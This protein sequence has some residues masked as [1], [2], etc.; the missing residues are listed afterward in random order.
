MHIL[1]LFAVAGLC[2]AY[3]FKPENDAGF[4]NSYVPALVDFTET[5]YDVAS[6][7][8]YWASSFITGDNERQYL[9]ILHILTTRNPSPVCRS[10]VLDLKSLDYWVDLTYCSP[11]NSSAS[12]RSGPLNVDF[13]DYGFGATSDDSVS[14]MYAYADTNNSFSLDVKWE[15]SS[16]AMQNG[17]GGIIAFGPGPSNATEW[18][19]PASRTSGSITLDGS[20]IKI[21]P[22]NSFTWYDRQISYGVPKNWTWFQV[23]FPGSTIKASI[24]AYDLGS[25]SNHVYQFATIRIN[26]SI[27]VLAFTLKP[28]ETKTWTSPN[29]GLT[30]PLSWKL[31]FQNGDYLDIESV[32]PDQE[33]F[34]SLSLVDSAYEGFVTVSGRFLGQKK[35]FGVVEMV[36]VY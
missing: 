1:T 6:G 32:R 29:S 25:P 11:Q 24:W 20:T 12:D 23:N 30:Y 28:D 21:N 26:N 36:T 18:G 19:I 15:A 5:Q 35:G 4:K 14:S 34:G 33:M 16:K 17:G 31:E 27:Q 2:S 3:V 7:S 13:G 8:S 10:S 9:A 22:K